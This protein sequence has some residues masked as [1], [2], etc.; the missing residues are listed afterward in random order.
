[1]TPL[2]TATNGFPGA[3]D[4]LLGFSPVAT[5]CTYPLARSSFA[6]SRSAV[7]PSDSRLDCAVVKTSGKAILAS[8]PLG[9]ATSGAVSVML[10]TSP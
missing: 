5:S 7:T 10:A 9:S 6:P 3:V 8:E 1:M 2:R 4:A